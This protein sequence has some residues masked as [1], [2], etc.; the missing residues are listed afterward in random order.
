M[1]YVYVPVHTVLGFRS[2]GKVLLV[3]GGHVVGVVLVPVLQVFGH[4]RIDVTVLVEIVNTL[5]HIDYDVEKQVDTLACAEHCGNHWHTE[6]LTE[7]AVVELIATLFKLV[8][9]VEG[10]NHAQVHIHKLGCKVE[11]ALDVACVHH[12][13]HHVGSFFYNLFAH[14]EFLGTV[15]RKG[16]CAR[17]V[18]DIELVTL[19]LGVS[20]LG[21]H[22]HAGVVAHPFV[23]P[24]SHVKQRSLAA[25]GVA[26]ESHI[27]GAAPL[28]GHFAQ[29][30]V[31]EG[32]LVGVAAV[33]HL[34]L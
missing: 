33:H 18:N 4:L 32:A 7:F 3:L 2:L 19:K 17:Q 22:G 26:H 34:R 30:F 12:V 8:E 14:I 9:H 23:R 5:I 28:H 6:E 24:R 21:I 11:V 27:D 20:L 29:L 25:V 10:A 31:G 13:Y 16:I 15:C 1:V